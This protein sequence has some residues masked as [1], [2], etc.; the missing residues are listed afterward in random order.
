MPAGEPVRLQTDR[1]APRPAALADF[2]A[3]FGLFSD[4]VVMRHRDTPPWTDRSQS[5]IDSDSAVPG[6]DGY[7]RLALTHRDDDPRGERRLLTR[8]PPGR[9]PVADPESGAD[10]SARVSFA[11][12]LKGPGNRQ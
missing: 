6:D 12:R 10:T 5:L 9:I 7:L 3:V 8:L 1:L 11:A 2:D 4:P